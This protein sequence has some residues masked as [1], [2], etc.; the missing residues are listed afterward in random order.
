MLGREGSSAHARLGA[1]QGRSSCVSQPETGSCWETK[2]LQQHRQ[3][4][5]LL[6]LFASPRAKKLQKPCDLSSRKS[7]DVG[8]LRPF[9]SQ[10]LCLNRAPLLLAWCRAISGRGL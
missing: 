1:A 8:R 2:A 5:S 10:K 4:S 7:S 9:L 6:Q 3:K